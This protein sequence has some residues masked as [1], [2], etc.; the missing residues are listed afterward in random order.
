MRVA[1]SQSNF[2]PW[3]GYF[4]LIHDVDLFIFLDSVQ[5]T[6]RDWRH[7][8]YIKFHTGTRWIRASVHEDVSLKIN[9]IQFKDFPWQQENWDLINQAYRKAPF[10]AWVAP[11]LEE[12][13]LAKK[14]ESLSDLNQF[15]I[16][17]ICADYL[18]I[19]TRF[20]QSSDFKATSAKQELILDLLKEVGAKTYISG[21]A[22]KAYI[23]ET[24]FEKEKIRLIWKDYAGYPQYSQL[25]PPF[26]HAVSVVDLLVHVGPE[27]P[28]YIWG[29][30]EKAKG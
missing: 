24:R 10:F 28:F 2:L 29:W 25:W 9:Q 23:E 6:K 20:A 8:N 4:D 17:R 21:P 15:L 27:A 11:L 14:W 19:H 12:V 3:K 7:R 13:F 22:A 30:R 5:Y 26:E 1:I 16:R 18:G